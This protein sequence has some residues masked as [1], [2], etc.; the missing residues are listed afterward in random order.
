METQAN[1]A[2]LFDH[3]ETVRRIQTRLPYLFQLAELESS[4]AG[5]AGMLDYLRL[6]AKKGVGRVP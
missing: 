1:L 3:K 4:Q 2:Q 6:K 5:K